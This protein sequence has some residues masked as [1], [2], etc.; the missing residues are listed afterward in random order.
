MCA[1]Q[2][3]FVGVTENFY[4]KCSAVFTETCQQHN[5][6]FNLTSYEE[7]SDQMEHFVEEFSL[8]P[9]NSFGL[10]QLVFLM[11]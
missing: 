1:I 8:I 9:I 7:G 6:T 10:F 5:C 3:L 2:D 4:D 11:M